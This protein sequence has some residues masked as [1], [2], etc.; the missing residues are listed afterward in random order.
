MD[1][2]LHG[3]RLPCGE[4]LS[5]DQVFN[6]PQVQHLTVAQAVNSKKLGPINLLRQPIT[7]SRTPS[8]LEVAPPERGEHTTEILDELGYTDEQIA[9]LRGR[10]IV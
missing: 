3:I 7:L 6:N 10:D 8:S 5:I 4:I 9:E 2:A 1:H